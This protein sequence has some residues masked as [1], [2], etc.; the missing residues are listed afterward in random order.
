MKTTMNKLFFSFTMK[1]KCFFPDTAVTT[2]PTDDVIWLSA[3]LCAA[4]GHL[5]GLQTKQQPFYTEPVQPA[6]TGLRQD[7]L[8]PKP[9]CVTLKITAA[10][11]AKL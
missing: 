5:A 2:A 8:A 1:M 6:I 4:A 11:E 10:G 7:T 9:H 3:V